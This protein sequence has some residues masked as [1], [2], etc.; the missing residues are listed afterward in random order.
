MKTLVISALIASSLSG[1][2]FAG[3]L[4]GDQLALSA[5][6]QPGSVTRV[7]AIQIID[8]KRENNPLA[9]RFYQTEQSGLSTTNG[10]SSGA[11][12]LAQNAGV[13]AGRFTSAELIQLIDAK[14]ENDTQR[15][16]YILS[17]ENRASANPGVTAG[18]QQLAALAGVNAADYTLAELVALQPTSDN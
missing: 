9:A 18:T 17:G 1:A 15:V 6:A 11:D 14:R 16:S 5:G 2:A 7:A 3:D 12:Q 8:A 13:E 10:A 4:A